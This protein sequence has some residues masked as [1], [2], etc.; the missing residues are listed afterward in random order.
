MFWILKKWQKK[1][2][3]RCPKPI[4]SDL[5]NC[6]KH[7][8]LLKN[9]LLEVYV[10]FIEWMWTV[11]GPPGMLAPWSLSSLLEVGEWLG[12][13]CWPQLCPPQRPFTLSLFTNPF[14]FHWVLS[15]RPHSPVRRVQWRKI[16]NLITSS[17]TVCNVLN[18]PY[19]CLDYL[20]WQGRGSGNTNKA[21]KE[22][23]CCREKSR[24]LIFYLWNCSDT[25]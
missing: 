13:A 17:T 21:R 8:V 4:I 10:S 9:S 5:R 23:G 1:V 20:N 24:F 12:S 11:E 14:C 15:K 6:G 22:G 18:E 3:D 25:N 7:P 16:S 2:S 19:K